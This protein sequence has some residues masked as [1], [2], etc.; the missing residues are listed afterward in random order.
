MIQ[1]IVVLLIM[2]ISGLIVEGI[3]SSSFKIRK[4]IKINMG[5]FGKMFEKEEVDIIKSCIHECL[6]LNY[7]V[8]FWL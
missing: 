7:I 1:F 8:F 4:Q 6:R 2:L 3:V 5:G